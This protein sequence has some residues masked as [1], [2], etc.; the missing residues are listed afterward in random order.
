MVKILRAVDT[1]RNAEHRLTSALKLTEPERQ[2]P[3]LHAS[4]IEIY[5]RQFKHFIRIE[6]TNIASKSLNAI[7]NAYILKHY[8]KKVS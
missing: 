5:H 1:H 3:A 2:Q 4:A 8:S 6:R 7:I